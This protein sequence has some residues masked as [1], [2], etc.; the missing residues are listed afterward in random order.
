MAFVI[1]HVF[2]MCSP[3][4]PEAVALTAAGLKE[5]SS[6]THPGQGTASRRFFFGNA[7]L[8]LAWVSDPGEARRGPAARTGLWERW[9][10]RNRDAS[11][12]G[13]VFG[14]TGS[15]TPEP[16][17]PTWSYHP[18]Y[19]PVAIDVGE[20]MSLHE[21]AL[22]YFRFPRPP[23]ALRAQPTAHALPLTRLTALTVAGPGSSPRS[24]PLRAAEATGV[25]AFPSADEHLMTLAFGGQGQTRDLRPELPL[26]LAW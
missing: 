10:K 1:D 26:V 7:Y 2:V 15:A 20:G 17:F 14:H 13:I 23:G 21:P 18:P 25:V 16:P 22:F 24:A 6:N 3:G 11:P 12:F 8:E 4:A 9:E 19:S 5:G